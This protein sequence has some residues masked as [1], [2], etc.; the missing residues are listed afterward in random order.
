MVGKLIPNLSIINYQ[1]FT[2]NA[3]RKK[4]LILYLVLKTEYWYIYLWKYVRFL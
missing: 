2:Q 4:P 1:L 3:T